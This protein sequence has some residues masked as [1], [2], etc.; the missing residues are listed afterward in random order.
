M[1]KNN[2]YA[3]IKIIEQMYEYYDRGYWHASEKRI[4]NLKKVYLETEGDME[5]NIERKYDP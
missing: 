4:D 5:E 2:P 1:K 3:Y